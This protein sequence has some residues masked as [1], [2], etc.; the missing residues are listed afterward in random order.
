MI[1]ILIFTIC[2]HIYKVSSFGKT[3][4]KK[5]SI[6]NLLRHNYNFRINNWPAHRLVGIITSGVSNCLA[7]EHFYFKIVPTIYF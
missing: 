5:I 4:D 3:A 2:G 6:M 1:I 7:R